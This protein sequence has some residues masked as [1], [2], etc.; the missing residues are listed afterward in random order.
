M[1]AYIVESDLLRGMPDYLKAHLMDDDHDGTV[2]AATITAVIQAAEGELDLY[3]SGSF[4]V[5][6]TGT[7]HEFLKTIAVNLAWY[8]AHKRIHRVSDQIQ[9]EYEQT[10]EQLQGIRDRLIG[11]SVQDTET[12]RPGLSGVTKSATRVF[13]RSNLSGL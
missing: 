10:I 9:T 8:H 5:P 13:G 4:V 12:L 7:I 2:D 1:G 3:L 11:G 6:L